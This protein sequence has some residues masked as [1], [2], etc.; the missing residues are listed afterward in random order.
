M[1]VIEFR[2]EQAAALKARAAAQ[3]LTLEEWFKE[4]ASP[5]HPATRKRASW[6]FS[7]PHAWSAWTSISSEAGITTETS[8]GERLSS[9]YELHLRNCP[10]SP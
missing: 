6:N 5:H 10:H 4:L 3:G 8:I 2:D 1:T 9:P 7:A